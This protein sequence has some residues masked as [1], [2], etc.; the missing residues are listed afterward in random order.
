METK[1]II[2]PIDGH[3]VVLKTYITGREDREI[4]N[5]YL[6]DMEV[7]VEGSTPKTGRMDMI[8]MT[9]AAE[10][11]AVEIIVVSVNEKTEN[12]FDTILDMKSTD[13]DFVKKAI[14]GI[15]DGNDFLDKSQTQNS[16]GNK[17][18]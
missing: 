4:S 11:K 6:R 3:R 14:D 16:G 5:I 7:K 8:K 18:K 10:K 17:D 13:T 2:T 12:V 15:K 9:E 1:E